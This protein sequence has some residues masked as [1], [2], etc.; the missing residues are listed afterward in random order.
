MIEEILKQLEDLTTEELTQVLKKVR[1]LQIKT[2]SILEGFINN[3]EEPKTN[4]T[5]KDLYN[6]FK[7]YAKDNKI[8]AVDERTFNIGISNAIKNKYITLN[9]LRLHAEQKILPDKK[10]VFG[11]KVQTE[12]VKP[13]KEKSI[14]SLYGVG[15][16]SE[17]K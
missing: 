11:D 8:V 15:E 6:N 7:S 1:Q 5:V 4:Y 17:I 13:I 16:I 3:F 9:K 2:T 14:A 10:I 12:E